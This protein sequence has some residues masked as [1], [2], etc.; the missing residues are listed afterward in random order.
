MLYTSIDT[1]PAA[2]SSM[3]GLLD[4]VLGSL[5]R[6]DHDGLG[7]VVDGRGDGDW[8]TVGRRIR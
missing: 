6:S 5:R 2:L 1:E 7:H 8:G 4:G 3:P